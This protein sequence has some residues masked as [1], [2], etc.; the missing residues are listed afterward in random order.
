MNIDKSLCASLQVPDFGSPVF[1]HS[2]HRQ[3]AQRLGK[4]VRAIAIGAGEGDVQKR[5]A[6]PIKAWVEILQ[7]EM[8]RDA[9]SPDSRRSC[10]P[11]YARTNCTNHD[12]S[13]CILCRRSNQIKGF[14]AIARIKKITAQRVRL[15]NPD[16]RM[17]IDP[18]H[19][20]AQKTNHAATDND[21]PYIPISSMRTCHAHRSD[22]TRRGQRISALPPQT[23]AW[24]RLHRLTT[25]QR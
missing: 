2:T 15:G 3:Q 13:R 4:V 16:M 22:S 9:A 17:V 24:H 6:P 21:N 25:R 23:A 14:T 18:H 10:R 5:K 8:N 1:I 20:R 12:V 11:C 19:K 7:A